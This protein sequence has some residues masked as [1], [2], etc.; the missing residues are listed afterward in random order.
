MGIQTRRLD[1]GRSTGKE[2]NNQRIVDGESPVDQDVELENSEENPQ[3][4]LVE[5]TTR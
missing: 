3:K 2:N 5:V 4:I 1:H